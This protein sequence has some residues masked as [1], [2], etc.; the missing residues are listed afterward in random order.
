MNT[1]RDYL[2]V[3]RYPT[4]GIRTHIKYA[5][6]LSP[7]CPDAPHPVL[8]CPDDAE[9]K[10]LRQALGLNLDR[11]ESQ[12]ATSAVDLLFAT[13]RAARK[14]RPAVIHSHGFTS[15]ICAS[16]STLLRG[17]RHVI[18]VHDVVTPGLVA[19][20]PK[21]GLLLLGLVLRFSYAVHAVGEDCATSLRALPFM[22]HARN[23]I[24]IRNGI[25]VQQFTSVTP[26]D[27]RT[28]L[29]LEQD[30]VLVGFFGRFMAQKG[31][32]TLVDAMR[33]VIDA[34]GT[35]RIVVIAVGSGAFIREDKDYIK[36]KGLSDSFFF[37]DAVENPAS[38]IA[39]VDMV[40]MPSRWEAYPLLAAEVLCL[41]VPLIAS[42]CIGLREAVR[43]TPAISL[44][45]DNPERLAQA[46]SEEAINSSKVVFAN[47]VETA[48]QRFDFRPNAALIQ[49]LLI[50][51]QRGASLAHDELLR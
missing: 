32:R 21:F 44:D 46:I 42:N 31:F 30:C 25:N 47:F 9:G 13:F 6:Q 48:I 5:A 8:V 2:L 24:T 43:D 10:A 7:P 15:A 49:R 33:F 19:R 12:H 39:G 4:G 38:L 28:K 18:T 36:S 23:L 37:L 50:D 16:P 11:F 17:V 45:P 1:N 3:V 14:W 41:G 22:R 51:A 20:T 40:A 35:K 26:A 27:L 29:S 34:A